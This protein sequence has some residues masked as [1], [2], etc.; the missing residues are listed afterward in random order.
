MQQTAEG[1]RH[2]AVPCRLQ[3]KGNI[4]EAK[5]QFKAGGLILLLSNH[6]PIVLVDG[7]SEERLTEQIGNSPLG[8]KWLRLLGS[9]VVNLEC[10]ASLNEIGCQG[11][12]HVTQTDKADNFVHLLISQSLVYLLVSQR[13]KP[14]LL[15]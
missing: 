3:G 6:A 11:Q 12:A 2:L 4:L 13:P 15:S 5:R 8:N 14:L 10:V 1:H 7:T 9:S